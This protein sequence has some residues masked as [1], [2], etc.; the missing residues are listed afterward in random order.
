MGM[1]LRLMEWWSALLRRGFIDLY[2]DVA[3]AFVLI[4][5]LTAVCLALLGSHAGA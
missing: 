3:L 4:L 2:I 5:V 1:R